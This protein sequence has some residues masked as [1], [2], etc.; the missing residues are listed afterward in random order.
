MEGA[1]EEK[2]PV[3]LSLQPERNGSRISLAEA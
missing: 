1:A 2:E 3:D